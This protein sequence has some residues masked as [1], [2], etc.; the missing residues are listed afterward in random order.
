MAS[1]VKKPA[2]RGST[3]R[4]TI[5][6]AVTDAVDS[7]AVVDDEQ[8]DETPART[9]RSA[10]EPDAPSRVTPALRADGPLTAASVSSALRA[11]G[12]RYQAYADVIEKVNNACVMTTKEIGTLSENIK[13]LDQEAHI[14][15]C[16]ML[17]DRE[18]KY[19]VNNY[20]TYVDL[21]DLPAD[22]LWRIH[23]YTTLCLE[24]IE[25]RKIKD[26]AQ[27]QWQKDQSDNT[28]Y[29][30]MKQQPTNKQNVFLQALP[31]YTTT[32]VTTY[33]ELRQDALRNLEQ[34]N[35]SAIDGYEQLEE[36]SEHDDAPDEITDAGDD[37]SD[38]GGYYDE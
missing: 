30:R 12:P 24:D 38:A 28:Q 29:Q 31:V 33:E 9:Q 3:A 16:R 25:R 37:L 34:C 20:G 18:Q 27:K 11:D 10:R 22:L 8:A 2:Q 36:A 6:H 7:P 23:Y 26:E 1:L 19:T 15:I 17:I 35:Y 13:K 5:K 21:I 4:K 32:T 14:E